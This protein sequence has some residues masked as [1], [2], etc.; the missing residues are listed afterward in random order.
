[1]ASEPAYGIDDASF[2]AAGKREGIEQLVN[3]FYQYMDTLPSAKVIRDMHKED[4]AE[5]IDKLTRFL[6]GW[7][8]GPKLFSAKYGTIRIPKAHAHL[9]IGYA[10]RDAWLECMEK[11]ISKQPYEQGFKKYLF[12]QL[13]VPAERSRNTT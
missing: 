5:S 1:V 4:L 13:A 7:L 10:E 3:D 8:G 12:A 9:S 2:I 6:C 11:A